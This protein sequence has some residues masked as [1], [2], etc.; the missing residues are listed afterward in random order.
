MTDAPRRP[1]NLD[2]AHAIAELGT[3]A[4]DTPGA[5]LRVGQVTATAPLTI[6]IGA[7]APIANVRRLTSYTPAVNDVVAVLHDS[8]AVLVLGKIT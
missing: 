8:T 6:T 3:T 5:R 1:A 4:G 7:G 2:L